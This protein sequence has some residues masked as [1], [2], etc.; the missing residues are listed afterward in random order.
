M[1]RYFVGYQEISEAEAKEIEKK[2]YEYLNSGDWNEMLKIR[3]IVVIN[4]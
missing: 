2:N 3:F 1:K 4:S